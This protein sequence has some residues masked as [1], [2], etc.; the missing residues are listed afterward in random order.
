MKNAQSAVCRLGVSL[1]KG[2][3]L[4]VVGGL[5]QSCNANVRIIENVNF[6][7]MAGI[8]ESDADA[9]A[10]AVLHL[11]GADGDVL[12][13]TSAVMAL[14]DGDAINAGFTLSDGMADVAT[15]FIAL[16]TVYINDHY[17]YLPIE[18]NAGYFSI[19][20]SKCQ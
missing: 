20:I 9:T 3:L 19:K 1:V 4:M 5:V 17:Y 16:L 6:V 8:A 15:L 13:I 10:F 12:A 7:L 18:V 11:A 14:F 2:M